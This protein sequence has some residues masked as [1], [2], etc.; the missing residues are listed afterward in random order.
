MKETTDLDMWL[1]TA[2]D[3]SV[4][5]ADLDQA[6]QVWRDAEEQYRAAQK[7]AAD[8]YKIA[9]EK[10]KLALEMLQR[11]GKTKYNVEGLGTCYQIN[12]ASVQTP[13]T[14]DDKRAFFRWL[15]DNHGEIVY[16]DKVSI[17]SQ[18]LNKLWNDLHAEAAENGDATFEIPGLQ[19]PTAIT[20][21]GFRKG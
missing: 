9:A 2:A 5:T 19:A 21:L 14:V 13:K 17:N 6:V 3:V 11:A 15:H 10:E 7:V 18:T 16:W 8:L 1:E 4:T 20:S 12:K